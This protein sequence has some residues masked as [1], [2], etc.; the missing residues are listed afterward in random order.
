MNKLLSRNS[1]FLALGICWWAGAIPSGISFVFVFVSVYWREA[2]AL[3]GLELLLE[4]L[5]LKHAV[6][7]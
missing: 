7:D 4:G 6:L 3:H 1:T 2:N 5:F